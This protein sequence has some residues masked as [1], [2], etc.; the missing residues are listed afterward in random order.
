MTFCLTYILT[1]D[2]TQNILFDVDFCIL[3][4]MLFEI[5]I[6]HVCLCCMHI[7]VGKQL[8]TCF[9]CEKR[10]EH[11]QIVE[12]FQ[13][14]RDRWGSSLYRDARAPLRP[15]GTRRASHVA[16]VTAIERCFS[17]PSRIEHRCSDCLN[18]S[19][20][21]ATPEVTCCW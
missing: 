16:P 3:F 4:G 2:L 21:F 1:S 8:I 9:F 5:L 14:I 15:D 19:M 18:W 7:F 11:L 10:A 17:C 6:S 20:G 12:A 13:R